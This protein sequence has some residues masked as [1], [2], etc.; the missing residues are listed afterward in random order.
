M[1]IFFPLL[2]LSIPFPSSLPPSFSFPSFLPSLHPFTKRV[3][4]QSCFPRTVLIFP[5]CT[6]VTMTITHF[7]YQRCLGVS[8]KLYDFSIQSTSIY[9]ASN[10][11]STTHRILC[12][13][14]KKQRGSSQAA[15]KSTNIEYSSPVTLLS[16]MKDEDIPGEMPWVSWDR[17]H[18]FLSPAR[19]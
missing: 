4:I 9:W 15:V 18:W 3:I 8:N 2:S 10:I 6:S 5:C 1:D 14:L 7:H 12:W 19:L 13:V 17:L 11:Q 16:A